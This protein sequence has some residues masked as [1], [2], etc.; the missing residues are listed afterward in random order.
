MLLLAAAMLC[1]VVLSATSAAA[2]SLSARNHRE[3][4]ALGEQ[5][6]AE[7]VELLRLRAELY[8]GRSH[9]KVRLLAVGALGMVPA[10]SVVDVTVSS[11]H[12][13]PSPVPSSAPA[14][15]WEGHRMLLTGSEG[16][17]YAIR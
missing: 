7:R 4:Y 2:R 11:S 13:P 5:V 15:G 8:E 10:D 17:A 16:L 6:A 14:L 9:E 12:V 1:A 3:L